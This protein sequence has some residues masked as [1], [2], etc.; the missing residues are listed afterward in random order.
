MAKFPS[1]K[2][3]TYDTPNLTNDALQD[4]GVLS[5]PKDL[6]ILNRRGYAS[7]T[8]KG[9]PLNY[10]MRFTLYS[11]TRAG[12][13]PAVNTDATTSVSVDTTSETQMAADATTL[14]RVTGCQNNWVMRNAAVKWHAARE[15]MFKDAGIKKSARGAYSHEIRYCYIAHDETL[16]TPTDGDGAD[17]A[18]GTW[19]ISQLAFSGD[20]EF[21]LALVGQGAD[22]EAGGFTGDSLSMGLS[23]LQSRLSQQADTN[24]ESEEGPSAHSVLNQML[25]GSA[26]HTSTVDDDIVDEA[27]NAQDNPPYDIVDISS[28]GDVNNDI[29]EPVLLGQCV[30]SISTPVASFI[31]DVPFGIA[32]IQARHSGGADQSIVDPVFFSAEVLKI[33]EMQ[34]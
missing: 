5:I 3:I 13:R 2:L 1:Q 28:S 32:K 33:S 15:Q 29:T 30:T 27:R 14:L 24:L 18:G 23:Y 34:G 7:T 17:L 6:S 20:N 19:D 11:M 26:V 25:S 31:C 4:C 9:V 22:E 8:R 10:R 16:M 21:A 12:K